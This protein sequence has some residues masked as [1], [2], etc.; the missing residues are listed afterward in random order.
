M[1][2]REKQLTTESVFKGHIM[3]VQVTTVELP[4]GQKTTREIVRHA[5]AVALLAL[6]KA[7]KMLLMKQWRAPIDGATL[8]IPAGKLDQRD[9]GD[10]LAAAKRELNEE[11][12]FAAEKMAE[13]SS[14]YTSVGFSDEYMT[15]Y[16]ATGLKA[17]QKALPQ[18]D[19][20]NL[21]L[22]EVSLSE[23]LQMVQDHQIEDAKTIM[24]IY[25]WQAKVLSGEL[26]GK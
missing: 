24:A 22:I 15:L 6:T 7:H 25:Y 11:T 20:E 10:A 5:A 8:E 21:E 3:D 9:Q 1:N 16:L 12:R 18:D 19:D 4:N 23:A 2:M 17:V 13:V 26:D 14:F